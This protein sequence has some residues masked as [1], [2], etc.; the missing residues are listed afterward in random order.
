MGRFSKWSRQG[1]IEIGISVLLLG[2]PLIWIG[3]NLVNPPGAVCGTQISDP[4]EGLAGCLITETNEPAISASVRL[5][6]SNVALSKPSAT[7]DGFPGM[8]EITD[9]T[10]KTNEYGYYE[11]KHP[12]V[13]DYDII[14]SSDKGASFRRRV[15]IDTI[16]QYLGKDKIKSYGWLEGTI[17]DDEWKTGIESAHGIDS[18]SC[19]IHWDFP[20]SLSTMN[21]KFKLFAPEG[22]YNMTCHKPPFRDTT[23][24]NIKIVAGMPTTLGD[25]QME[26]G[27]PERPG[28]SPAILLAVYDSVTG[29]VNLSWP[30]VAFAGFAAYAIKRTD[31]KKIPE[32]PIFFTRELSF[33]DLVYATRADS[34][35]K[36]LYYSITCMRTDGTSTVEVGKAT[37]IKVSPPAKVGADIDLNFASGDS[38]L[39]MGATLKVVVDY[40][41]YLRI[42]TKLIWTLEGTLKDSSTV[43]KTET[44][45]LA[46]LAGT[47]IYSRVCDVPGNWKLQVTI[48][49]EIGVSNSAF[50]KFEVN[51]P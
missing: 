7:S 45:S 46:V 6:P 19:S 44:L 35:S 39:A 28:K 33:S 2:S 23:L 42:N 47:S 49:D 51:K 16:P 8:A 43:L 37:A 15:L 22:T 40:R 24:A 12:P 50:L 11:I 38:H 41:N 31:P 32:T 20:K 48:E 3:C 18:V 21:G 27:D 9:F 34:A 14:F 1:C 30:K 13:G 26:K 36:D 5:I 4:T 29:R 17:I 10:A 25:L